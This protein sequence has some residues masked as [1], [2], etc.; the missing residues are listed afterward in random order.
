MFEVTPETELFGSAPVATIGSEQVNKEFV[1]GVRSKYVLVRKEVKEEE[2]PVEMKVDQKPMRQ[3]REQLVKNSVGSKIFDF[4][5]GNKPTGLRKPV[6][7]TNEPKP[8]D[9]TA[10]KRKLAF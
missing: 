5:A 3:E 10:P 8:S 4:L 6:P 7:K 2:K 1:D 9:S